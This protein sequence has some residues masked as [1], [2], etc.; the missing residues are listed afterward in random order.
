MEAFS[1]FGRVSV[2]W[3]HKTESSSHFPPKGA[4]RCPE[5]ESVAFSASIRAIVFVAANS[6]PLHTCPLCSPQQPSDLISCLD[7]WLAGYCFVLFSTEASALALLG[8]CRT[9]N[10]GKQFFQLSSAST[11]DKAVCRC[12]RCAATHC[13]TDLSS[14]PT[15]NMRERKR[16]Q[17]LPNRSFPLSPL[18]YSIL[19]SRPL[20]PKVSTNADFLPSAR[21]RWRCCQQSA[22]L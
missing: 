3:P 11:R 9:E 17:S 4:R 6:T 15:T 12:N 2:D 1:R 10:G 19:R 5:S 14:A 16:K 22:A 18:L 13:P 7:L 20:R 21:R 8:S